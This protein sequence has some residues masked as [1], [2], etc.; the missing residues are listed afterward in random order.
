[1]FAHSLD[2]AMIGHDFG[3]V[4]F[5]FMPKHVHLLVFSRQPEGRIDLLLKAMKRPFA[6]RVKKQLE[7][8]SSPLLGQ[9][10]VGD[11]PGVDRFRFWQ[12][13]GG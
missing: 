12:E 6:F 8:N 11:R 9:L 13:G 5:V 1:M 10:T 2:R 3:L 7:A 4:A